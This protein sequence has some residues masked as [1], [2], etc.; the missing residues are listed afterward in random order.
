MRLPASA[1]RWDAIEHGIGLV[2]GNCFDSVEVGVSGRACRMKFHR[3]V[4][5]SLESHWSDSIF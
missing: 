1:T 3:R 5:G 2:L 4:I